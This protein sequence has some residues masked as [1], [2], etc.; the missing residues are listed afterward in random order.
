MCPRPSIRARH[1]TLR[2]ITFTACVMSMWVTHAHAQSVRKCEVDGRAV[3][4]APPCAVEARPTTAAAAAPP[5]SA[6]GPRK[7]TLAEL[8]RERDGV[9]RERVVSQ[10]LQP[11]GAAVLRARMGAV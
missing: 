10:P 2:S 3:F 1:A 9:G 11:D 7:K 4:Q 6:A 5:A 8:L